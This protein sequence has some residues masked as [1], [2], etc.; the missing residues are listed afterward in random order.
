M[1]ASFGWRA[2]CA[3][4]SGVRSRLVL[5][6]QPGAGVSEELNHGAKAAAG[7][8]GRV[9]H[10]IAGGIRFVDVDP[11]SDPDFDRGERLLL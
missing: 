7:R 3:A 10:G 1:V 9:H 4:S 2:R 11:G 8:C 5:D 6:I